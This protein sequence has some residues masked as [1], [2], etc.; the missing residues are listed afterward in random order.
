MRAGETEKKKNKE[1]VL[2]MTQNFFYEGRRTF[3]E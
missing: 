2:N 3:R 1:T